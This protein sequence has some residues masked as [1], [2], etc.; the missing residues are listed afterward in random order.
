MDKRYR[1]ETR[2]DGFILDECDTLEQARELIR[3]YEKEDE[4]EENVLLDEIR[5]SLKGCYD[6]ADELEDY[7]QSNRYQIIYKDYTNKEIRRIK[8]DGFYKIYDTIG[9]DEVV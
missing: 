9:A 3:A 2:I 7:I 6:N 5:Q 4:E 8:W 1:V